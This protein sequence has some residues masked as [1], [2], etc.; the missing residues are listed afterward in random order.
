MGLIPALPGLPTIAIESLSS[1]CQKK[2]NKAM[3]NGLKE[4]KG[5]ENL[6]YNKLN[7]L[8]NDFLLYGKYNAE[9]TEK[10]VLTINS[11]QNRT[12]RL[13]GLFL[14]IKMNG[15]HIICLKELGILYSHISC[16][17]VHKSVQKDIT[18]CVKPYLTAYKIF[19]RNCHFK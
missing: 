19:K 14:G 8:V 9:N 15:L 7:K 5:N 10:I 16:N 2:I 6:Q 1:Y 4:L 13:E 3:A 12:S 17:Y 11:Q 18:D